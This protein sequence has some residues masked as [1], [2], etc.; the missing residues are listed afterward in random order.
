MLFFNFLILYTVALK[1]ALN[2]GRPK[3]CLGVIRAGVNGAG[4]EL[5]P[6]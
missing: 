2:G 5:G 6:A 1:A 4:V 3:F